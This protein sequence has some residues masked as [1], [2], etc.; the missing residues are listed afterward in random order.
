ML[1]MILE[2]D[3]FLKW[4]VLFVLVVQTSV[5]VTLFRLS[6]TGSSEHYL[7]SSVVLSTEILKYIMCLLLLLCQHRCSL[8][9]AIQGYF[10]EVVNKPRQTALLSVPACLY[11]VQNNILVL[12]LKHLDAATFQV[13]YQL[14]IITTAGFS[15]VLLGKILDPRQWLSLIMLTAGVGIVQIPATWTAT[16]IEQD[17]LT[18]LCA[19]L[20]A[21]FSSGFAGVFYEKLLKNSSQPSIIIRNLQLGIFSILFGSINMLYRDWDAIT[22]T[23]VFR[24]YSIV[25]WIVIGLQSV[26]GLLVAATIKYADNIFKGFAT[27]LSILLSALL[28]WLITEDL[29]PGI[30]FVVGTALVLLS[31]GIYSYTPR[32]RIRQPA[33]SK[34]PV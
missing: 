6:L 28:S 12:A 24:G 31:S 22:E 13:T 14:K 9:S 2:R 25:V 19:V 17:K 16:S 10:S 15:V 20:V 11:T 21:C 4:A 32:R 33:A 29:R 27:S 3:H 30:Q 34:L 1:K 23:G 7:G 8:G 18:G 5:T 26:G